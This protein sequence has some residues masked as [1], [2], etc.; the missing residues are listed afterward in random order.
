MT[1]QG[2]SWQQ[3]HALLA[4]KK[5]TSSTS[6]GIAQLSVLQQFLCNRQVALSG[7][8]AQTHPLWHTSFLYN[9]S[10]PACPFVHAQMIIHG[11]TQV[12]KPNLPKTPAAAPKAANTGR[13]LLMKL[14][15]FRA[16]T[17]PSVVSTSL[18]ATQNSIRAAVDGRTDVATAAAVGGATANAATHRCWNCVMG[19][20]FQRT[21]H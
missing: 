2:V 21:G 6:A 16:G 1:G 11:I 15:Q 14:L 12:L 5:R 9:I 4:C 18:T 17:G 7:M 13:K 8:T 20:P 19:D 3:C 10:T